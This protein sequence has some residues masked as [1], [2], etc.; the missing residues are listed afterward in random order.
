MVSSHQFHTWDQGPF[1]LPWCCIDKVVHG[2]MYGI[3][4]K[5]PWCW[6]D[7][8][9]SM[10]SCIK[11]VWRD[12]DV[13]RVVYGLM[14][15]IGVKKQWCCMKIEWSLISCMKL[16]RKDHDAYSEWFMVSID[17]SLY[18]QHRGLFTPIPDHRPLCLYNIMVSS[19]QFHTWD[20]EP[21]S[22]YATSW[23]LLTNSIQDRMVPGLMYETGEKRPWCI[24]SDLWSH[25]WNWREETMVL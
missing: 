6:I 16:V 12:H 4:E 22:V 17:H 7:R 19:H 14:Y 20:Q 21:L 5:S 13:Y 8:D 24:Y 1:Y 2:L 11:L 23:S 3:S 18:I 15:G 9:W 10:V 25:V